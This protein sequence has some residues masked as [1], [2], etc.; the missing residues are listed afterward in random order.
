MK[1][2]DSLIL[3]LV[4]YALMNE[5]IEE[6]DKI[7]VTN[8]LLEVF[9]KIGLNTDSEA[10]KGDVE[11]KKHITRRISEILSDCLE[12]AI[13]DGLI[14]DTQLNRD[15]FDTKIMGVLT[16]MPS[17]VRK[18]FKELYNNSP[19]FATDYFY[20]LNKACNYIRC[21]RIEKDQ[22]WKCN[23]E[24]GTI[25]ITINLSKPEKDPKDIIK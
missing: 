15:I 13:K 18:H 20:E 21:D 7:Y 16:P 1:D 22:K 4:N 9:E 3:E 24:Y 12:T 23:S 6:D 10:I 8:R 17:V 2:I 25:D 14:E 5:L 11:S 19:K